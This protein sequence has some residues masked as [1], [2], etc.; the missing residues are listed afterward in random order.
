MSAVERAAKARAA[1][2]SLKGKKRKS[3]VEQRLDAAMSRGLGEIRC[4]ETYSIAVFQQ[5]TGLKDVAVR[6]AIL[7]GLKVGHAGNQ[8]YVTG[9]EW[10]RFIT[11][12]MSQQQS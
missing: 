7:E 8:R 2:K 6:K 4:G 9:D 1:R 10:H 5:R 3:R 11:E 12:K